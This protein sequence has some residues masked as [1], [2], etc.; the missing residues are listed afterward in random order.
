MSIQINKENSITVLANSIRL[1]QKMGAFLMREAKLLKQAIDYFNP[2][3]KE[4]PEIFKDVENPEVVAVNLLLQGVQKAQSHGGELAYSLEDAAVLWDVM[5][6][7]IKEGGK[8]VVQNVNTKSADKDGKSAKD[9]VNSARASSKS[10]KEV[11][12][13]KDSD[14]DE[15]DDE[16]KPLLSVKA[17]KGKS[18]A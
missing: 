13:D 15:D 14:D 3:V 16:I 4:K 18:M 10:T 9:A 1:G 8:Q 6:F 2:E 7:W 11:V 5:E 17:S 12:H